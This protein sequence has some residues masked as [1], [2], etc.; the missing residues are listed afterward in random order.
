[1]LLQVKNVS[2]SFSMKVL[3]NVSMQVGEGEVHALLGLNGAGKSTLVNIICGI[4]S[5]FEGEV[6]FQGK[7]INKLSVLERQEEGIFMVPQHAAIVP[8]Y[9]LAENI[10]IGKWPLKRRGVIDHDKMFTDAKRE[11][12]AYGL[13]QDPKMKAGKLSL[14]DRR[15][16]NI[17]RALYSNAKLIVLDEPTTSLDADD[18]EELFDFVRDLCSKGTSFIFISHY[19]DEVMKI[20]HNI[21]VLRDGRAF[22]HKM[23]KSDAAAAAVVLSKEIVGEDVE[24]AQRSELEIEGKANMLECHDLVGDCMNGISFEVRAGEIV[25]MCGLPGSGLRETARGLFGQG[26]LKSG[27]IKMNGKEMPIPKTSLEAMRRKLIYIPNDRH[28][29]GLVSIMSIY[30]NISLGILNLKLRKA[31]GVLDEKKEA[32]NVARYYDVL[33]I[34]AKSPQEPASVLSGGN[35]QK[36]VVAKALCCEPDLLI[37]DEPT[38]G[39]DVHTREEILKLVDNLTILGKSAIYITND[40]QELLRICDRILIFQNG[41]VIQNLKN[42]GLDAETIIEFMDEKGGIQNESAIS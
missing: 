31:G 42:E 15:K 22:S 35:Q 12:E 36:V 3:D 41:K 7:N 38:I 28:L 32:E 2:K 21:T 23:D 13:T 37:L 33:E 24:L 19:L 10:F 26:T 5:D 40:Y 30:K 34:K 25:G 27:T 1:M 29:E 20:S 14:I 17:I 39:I 18:R 6:L 11:L 8:E 16:L 4:Y 9:S